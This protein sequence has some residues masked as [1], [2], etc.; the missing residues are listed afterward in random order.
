MPNLPRAKGVAVEELSIQDDARADAVPDLDHDEILF[1]A[2]LAKGMLG[3]GSHL[4]VVGD[5]DGQVVTLLEQIAQGQVLPVE[6][7]G[8][9][10]DALLRIHQARCADA[11]AQQGAAGCRDQFV[12]EIVNERQR[13][14]AVPAIEGQGGLVSDVAPQVD[15]CPAKLAAG[16]V[17]ADEMVRVVRHAQ[18]DGRLAADRWPV[19]DLFYEPAVQQPG[20]DIRNGRAREAGG[21]SDAGPADLAVVVDGLEHQAAVVRFGLPTGRLLQGMLLHQARVAGGH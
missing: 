18:Q 17:D 8:A 13:R 15:H 2:A 10:H 7:D 3:Q 16:Q 1:V 19:A 14:R 5:I 12:D 6:V 21:A 4:R 9:A 11:D 20:N